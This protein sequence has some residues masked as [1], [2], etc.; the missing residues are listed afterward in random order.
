MSA[1]GRNQPCPCG[2][3]R[4][5]KRCCGQQRG[6]SDDQLARARL[7]T[8]AAACVEE[9][10]VLSKPTIAHLW[11]GLFDLPGVDLSLHVELPALIGPDLHRL[12]EVI[13]DDAEIGWD[14]VTTV[15][16]QVDTP[17]QRLRLAEALVRLRDERR[18]SRQQAAFAIFEL[19][20]ETQ[21]LLMA[22]VFHT[23]SVAVGVSDTP[24]WLHLAA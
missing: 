3:G 20:G 8:L 18:I 16:N 22:S 6:P 21:T 19:G 17:G 1:S 9:L 5:V 12:R 13:A 15:T 14:E 24:G 7:A 23:V 10:G 11:K 2:S 4:K